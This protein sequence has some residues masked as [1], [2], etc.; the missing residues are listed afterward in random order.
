MKN[1][2]VEKIRQ[3]LAGAR[4]V[5]ILTHTNPDG[6]AIGA[7]LGLYHFLKNKG[8]NVHVVVPSMYPEFL[9]WM[10]GATEICNFDDD[11][12]LCER[13][14]IESDVL[15][16]VDFNSPDRLDA[17]E[18]VFMQRKATKVL[19]D[20]HIDRGQFCDIE[21]K[22]INVSSTA[23]LIYL[24]IEDLGEKDRINADIASCLYV[25][26]MT[27]TGSFSYA[28]NSQGTFRVVSELMAFGIDGEHIHR[29]V[30]DTYSEE[31]L[32]LLGYCLSDKLVVMPEF[33]TAYIALSQKE[34][35]QFHYKNGDTEGVVNFTLGIKGIIFGALITERKDRVK[36]SLRSKG[37]FDVN[38]LAIEHFNG[39]GHKNASGGDLYCSFDEAVKLFRSIIPMYGVELKKAKQ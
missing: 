39:G 27:D 31:R 3:T 11:P 29:M 28:C 9:S 34:L 32:R 5:S 6:D 36:I 19:I 4:E 14:L 15:F 30:Y 35:D 2:V 25:G 33:G 13:Y 12:S 8:I 17:M 26:I 37:H 7:G 1:E 22:S 21:Y 24:L 10:P 38:R 18:S 16:C 20:H 23:E